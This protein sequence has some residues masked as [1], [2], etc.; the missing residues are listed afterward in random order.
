MSQQAATAE[1]LRALHDMGAAQLSPGASGNISVRVEGGMLVS[2]SG[3]VAA[4]ASSRDIAFV[5]ESCHSLESWPDDQPRPSSEWRMHQALYNSHP[6]AMA[7]VHC[8]SLHATALAC[9]RRRIPPFHYMVSIAGGDDIPCAD[10][11]LFGSEELSQVVCNTLQHR[12]ACLMANHG[13]I[14]IG[15]SAAT[16]LA[17]AREVE[18]LAACYLA[19]L[20]NGDPV[21]LT[22][23]EMNAVYEAFSHYG[24]RLKD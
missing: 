3:A 11:A 20:Q 24:Q 23:Q 19:S 10:Y 7:V 4:N 2:A 16:A 21:L 8:H 18:S 1:L 5:P 12:R 17:L 15:D 13:Q 9:Q 22:P 6:D 14:C